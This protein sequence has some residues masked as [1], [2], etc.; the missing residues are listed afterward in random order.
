MNEND[1]IA[2][3]WVVCPECRRQKCLGRH[4]CP[5]LK[6]VAKKLKEKEKQNDSQRQR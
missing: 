1:L 2:L 6:S 5:E 3:S 4:K